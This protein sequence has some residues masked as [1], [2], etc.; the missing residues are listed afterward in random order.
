MKGAEMTI[1][2]LVHGAPT[3]SRGAR[4]AGCFAEPVRLVRPLADYP[5]TRTYIKATGEPRPGQPRRRHEPRPC[6][7]LMDG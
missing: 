7:F 2:V 5:F 6:L 1:F 3:P 4:P